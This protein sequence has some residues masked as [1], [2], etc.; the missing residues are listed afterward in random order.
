VHSDEISRYFT[1]WGDQRDKDSLGAQYDVYGSRVDWNGNLLDIPGGFLISKS[2]NT[3]VIPAVGYCGSNYLVAWSDTR[4]GYFNRDLYASLLSS[5]GTIVASPIAIATAAS[6]QDAPAIACNGTNFYV[7]WT[8]RRNGNPDIYG[9]MLDG[10]TGQVLNPG[11]VAIATGTTNQEHPAVAYGAGNF[12]VVWDASDVY[13]VF[14]TIS[15]TT[16]AVLGGPVTMTERDHNRYPDVAFDGTGFWVVWQTIFNGNQNIAGASLSAS[17]TVGA[18]TTIENDAATQRYPKV[19]WDSTSALYTVVYEDD[20]NIASTNTD[21]Y[22]RSFAANGVVNAAFPVATKAGTELAPHIASRTAQ[23]H[24]VVY[25]H[26]A[27]VEAQAIDT[28]VAQAIYT[29]AD[30]TT[31]LMAYPAI[32]CASSSSCLVPYNSVD[33]QSVNNPV[34]RIKARVV[35]YP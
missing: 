5:S 3:E 29:I 10:A 24:E 32:A 13:V 19:A 26:S 4:N 18:I 21:I 28:G 27:N 2:V 15:G 14:A 30:G 20:R 6:N 22:A 31:T 23:V 35:S 1:V 11:G 17:G 12:K 16:G 7:V 34:F 33:T 25:Q 8:D 9:S